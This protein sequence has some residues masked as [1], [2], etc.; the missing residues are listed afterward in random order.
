[1]I[2][3]PFVMTDPSTDQQVLV[4]V[5]VPELPG[6]KMLVTIA[7]RPD[8]WSSWGPPVELEDRSTSE[9]RAEMELPA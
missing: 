6:E 2:Y 1:M 5:Y 4:S 8:N 9:A 3:R 7:T